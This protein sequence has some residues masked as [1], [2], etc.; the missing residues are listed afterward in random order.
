[1]ASTFWDWNK[2]VS[3]CRR[4]EA[5]VS[6]KRKWVTIPIEFRTGESARSPQKVVPSFR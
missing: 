1:M 6:E 3:A 2:A 4:T 5:S